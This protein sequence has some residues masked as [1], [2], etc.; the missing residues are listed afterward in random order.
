MYSR[1]LFLKSTLADSIAFSGSMLGFRGIP[2]NVLVHACVVLFQL[3]LQCSCAV[4]TARFL[5]QWEQSKKATRSMRARLSILHVD[6]L[7]EIKFSNQV[8]VLP[9]QFCSQLP[10][11]FWRSTQKSPRPNMVHPLHVGQQGL[12]GGVLFFEWVLGL[13]VNVGPQGFGAEFW[14]AV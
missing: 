8:D 4:L 13:V 10:C 7:I 2:F 5:P 6:P 3:W 9:A 14:T 12:F 11:T 1:F